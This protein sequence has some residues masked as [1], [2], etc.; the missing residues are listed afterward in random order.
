MHATWQS[1]VCFVI[2]CTKYFQMVNLG[3][4]VQQLD[5]STVKPCCCN[6]CSMWFTIILLSSISTNTPSYYQRCKLLKWVLTSSRLDPL[7]VSLGN[8][9]SIIQKKNFKFQPRSSFSL[10]PQLWPREEGGVSGSCS[11]MAPYLHDKALTCI[12]GWQIVFTGNDF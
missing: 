3:R 8:T 7:L 5:S 1:C 4:P 11:H 6:G 2:F 9:A 10:F 12:C